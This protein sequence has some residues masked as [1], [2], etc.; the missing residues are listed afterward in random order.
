MYAVI[1]ANVDDMTGELAGHTI[2]TLMKAGASVWVRRI[3]HLVHGRQ[4]IHGGGSDA[5]R[6]AVL[7]GVVADPGAV[8]PE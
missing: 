4:L 3:V 2:A 1:E 8:G 6:V 7:L 5:R